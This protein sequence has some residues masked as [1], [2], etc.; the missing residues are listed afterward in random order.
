MS[1]RIVDRRYDVQRH[2]HD[3]RNFKLRRGE[4][5]ADFQNGFTATVQAATLRLAR[6]KKRI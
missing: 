4:I 1:D 2:G 3:R 5:Q 6:L